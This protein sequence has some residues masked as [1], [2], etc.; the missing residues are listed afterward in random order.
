MR[1]QRAKRTVSARG[2][3]EWPRLEADEKPAHTEPG[4][5]DAFD[6]QLDAP[7]IDCREDSRRADLFAQALLA[8]AE[9]PGLGFKGLRRV[10][11]VFGDNLPEA[12]EAG[13]DDLR[14]RLENNKV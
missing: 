6:V 12:L 10:V 4:L 3:S 2:E 8:L 7:C 14:A 9:L 1:H 11:S 5:F 13:R